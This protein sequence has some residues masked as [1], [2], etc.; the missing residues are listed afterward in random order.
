MRDSPAEIKH[1]A[2]SQLAS[3]ALACFKTVPKATGTLTHAGTQ[4]DCTHEE[5]HRANEAQGARQEAGRCES[6]AAPGEAHAH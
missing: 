1:A 4:K 6:N 2:N 3:R 5:R